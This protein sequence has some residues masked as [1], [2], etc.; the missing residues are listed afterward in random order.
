MIPTKLV[1][2]NFMCYRDDVTL[3]LRTVRVA[4]ISGDNGAGKSSLLDAIT[5]VLWGKARGAA[6]RDLMTLGTT[7]MGV[8]F[9]F[10]LGTQEFRVLRRRRRRG[11][12]QD[13]AQLE[14][15]VRDLTPDGDSPWRPITGDTLSQT[16]RLLSDAIGME[17]D[18]F[19][20]SAFILQGRADE[21]TTKGPTDR[22]QVLADILGLGQYD[23]LEERARGLRRER[24]LARRDCDARLETI[25]G[26]LTQRPGIEAQLQE[27]ATRLVTLVG[28][29]AR[30]DDELDALK[31]QRAALERQ[32]EAA[33]EAELRAEE[34]TR[35]AESL[36]NRIAADANQIVVLE[37]L[38]TDAA[39]IRAAYTRLQKV[40]AAEAAMTGKLAASRRLEQEYHDVER[41]V[42]AARSRLLQ[43]RHGLDHQMTDL[44]QRQDAL[45]ELERQHAQLL[46]SVNAV[47][48]AEDQRPALLADI[49]TTTEEIGRRRAEND[50]LLKEMK[51]LK[52]LQTQVDNAGAAC[53]LCRRPLD[54]HDRHDIHDNYQAEGLDRKEQYNANRE[55]VASAETAVAGW[56]A[57]LAEIDR[58]VRQG[59][60]LNNSL[61]DVARQLADIQKAGLQLAALS[62]DFEQIS[63]RLNNDAIAPADQQHLARLGTQI[64]ALAYDPDQHQQL[65][66]E[67]AALR[68]YER[69]LH[70]LE[71]AEE[72]LPVL[73][74]RLAED[75]T[76]LALR[77][78][79]RDAELVRAAELRAAVTELPRLIARCDDLV[80]ALNQQR[81][82]Q[83]QLTRQQGSL[84][85]DLRRLAD[86]E[87]ESRELRQERT[88][89][90]D[91]E[92]VY[93]DLAKAFGK[94]GI[95]AMII[96]A[97]VPEIQDEANAILA[98]M[99]GNTM[100]V[101]FRTQRAT[102]KGDTVEAL[103]ILIGDEAGQRAYAMYSGGE[104]FRI[105]FA[106]RVALAKLLARRAGAK[107]QLLVID[108]GFGSQ[109]ARG[110]DSL[111]EAIRSIEPDFATI[112]IITHVSELK[113]VFPTQIMIEK[114]ASGSQI[115]VA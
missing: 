42:D 52:N 67:V 6:E 60:Q 94:T 55:A 58:I 69:Q 102:Q 76:S 89:L 105:N 15:Q 3:D 34:Y 20:N 75:Q 78:T 85:A 43:E 17:Y 38:V 81:R 45:P 2:H 79:A 27:V 18:T 110:R 82:E 26:E 101:E 71:R 77:E 63:A 108:E 11:A 8:D 96:E 92:G 86:L 103:D 33:R 57:R 16:Q 104:S 113:E 4:C 13:V 100:R 48:A 91:E 115:A 56:Q 21:F 72:E 25:A 66:A 97:A 28:E 14:V 24:E 95:Q 35:Q 93:R 22:K 1:L 39:A 64:A 107:L 32:A 98:N 62:A 37:A 73:R 88:R 29:I 44:R 40:T 114:T 106:I 7:E 23:L 5:W 19:I 109:D 59:R 68:P 49:Q 90:T 36:R 61:G 30:N 51:R 70:D 83:E 9:Q 80:G 99:P 46:A 10:V 53:P 31:G 65:H 54:E 84:E 41:Q 50:Y 12:S 111:V 112:L 87:D 47:R 74:E